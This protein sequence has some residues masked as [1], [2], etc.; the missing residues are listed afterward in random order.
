MSMMYIYLVF[1]WS[2]VAIGQAQVTQIS[3]ITLNVVVPVIKTTVPL[4]LQQPHSDELVLASSPSVFFPV[5]LQMSFLS[6]RE[7]H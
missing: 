4:P 3:Y 1:L 5:S 2:A 6:P 7:N